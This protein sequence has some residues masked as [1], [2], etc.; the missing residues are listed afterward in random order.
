[1]LSSVRGKTWMAANSPPAAR[2]SWKTA[3][4]SVAPDAKSARASGGAEGGAVTDVVDMLS[5]NACV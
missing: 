5:K 4:S 1:M 2:Y 3:G